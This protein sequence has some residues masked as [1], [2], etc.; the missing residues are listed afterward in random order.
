MWPWKTPLAEGEITTNGFVA[1][2]V[3]WQIVT[4][5]DAE[6]DT[7]PLACSL[8]LPCS[9][10]LPCVLTCGVHFVPPCAFSACTSTSCFPQPVL[11]GWLLP[12]PWST[13]DGLAPYCCAI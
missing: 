5:S 13:V 4:C 1:E 12:G 11:C 10:L 8:L 2:P 9:P 6:P 7:P 3:A